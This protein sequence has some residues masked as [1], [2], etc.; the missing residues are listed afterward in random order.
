VE[1]RRAPG[2]RNSA[3]NRAAWTLGRWIAAGALKQDDVEDELYSAAE[4]NALVAVDGDR[5][6]WAT[7]RSGLSAGLQQPIDLHVD[8]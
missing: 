5:Q 8:V 4:S 1:P 7:I 6:C 2:A 3:L